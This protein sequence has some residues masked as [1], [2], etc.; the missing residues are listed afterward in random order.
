[1]KTMKTAYNLFLM[2]MIFARLNGHAQTVENALLW[3]V[4]G[5]GLAKPSYI[6]GTMHVVCEEDY[7]FPD[8]LNEALVKTDQVIFEIDMDAP[9]LMTQM[10]ASMM[11]P[12]PLSKKLSAEDYQALDSVLLQSTSMSLSML[13]NMTLQTISSIMM[14]KSLPCEAPKS[15]E[16]DLVALATEKQKEVLGLETIADQ[17]DFMGKAFSD[18]FLLQQ[19]LDY[20]NHEGVFAEMVKS[21]NEQNLNE[22]YAFVTDKKYADQDTEKWL[23][24]ERNKNWAEA[25]PEMIRNESSLI[26]VGAAHLPGENGIIELLRAKGYA[27]K[28]VRK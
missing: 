12:I 11:S 2:I 8:A 3:E 9:D 25:L 28:P 17:M 5:N 23:L 15:Y 21:Y 14:L 20:N 27:V 7:I 26:A 22:L 6:Y 18:E 24:I 1:M 16:A 13:D 19:L 10:Q 4:S